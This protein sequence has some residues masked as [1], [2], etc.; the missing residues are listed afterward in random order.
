M[1]INTF[2]AQTNGKTA[3]ADEATF[4]KDIRIQKFDPEKMDAQTWASNN[5]YELEMSGYR[6]EKKII[7]KLLSGLPDELRY[8]VRAD[9]QN[10]YPKVNG[11]YG[12]TVADFI[13]TLKQHAM[14]TTADMQESLQML[15]LGS[16][17]DLR[18]F[19]YQI[20]SLVDSTLTDKQ[21]ESGVAELIATAKFREKL[22]N[23]LRNNQLIASSTESGLKLVGLAQRVM[24]RCKGVLS[25]NAFNTRGYKRA[26]EVVEADTAEVTTTT[27]TTTTSETT[28][29]PKVIQL[30][31][32]K[33]TTTT[34]TTT[35]ET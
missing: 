23:Y 15:T 18:R 10:N 21:R 3:N 28:E 16:Q 9:L 6:N 22:P 5:C 26:V 11:I 35:T 25:A 13:K 12:G 34:A 8:A 31:T 14:Q 30:W 27:T 20:K 2:T 4:A 7:A 17:R 19:F 29:T 1:H 24:N 32:T 33:T